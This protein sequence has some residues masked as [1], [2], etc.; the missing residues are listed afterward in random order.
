MPGRHNRSLEAW[1]SAACGDIK[2]G[3]ITDENPCISI[4]NEIINRN[5]FIPKRLYQCQANKLISYN[6]YMMS[7][8]YT[9]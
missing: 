6:K 1:E 5:I 8:S 4:M 7:L 3:V 9:R 2:E